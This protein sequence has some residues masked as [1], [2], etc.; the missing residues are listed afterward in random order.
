MAAT[1]HNE[2]PIPELSPEEHRLLDLTVKDLRAGRRV[3]VSA[4]QAR[5]MRAGEHDLD[6]IA[7]ADNAPARI[8]S[9][10]DGA[11]RPT[12]L[13]LSLVPD[14]G[15]LEHL[16]LAIALAVEHYEDES[17]LLTLGE[18]R[19]AKHLSRRDARCLAAVL[20]CEQHIFAAMP[21]GPFGRLDPRKCWRIDHAVRHFADVDSP[22]A[23]LSVLAS[24]P[25]AATDHGG[26]PTHPASPPPAWT[27]RAGQTFVD[28]LINAAATTLLALAVWGI[29]GPAT[30]QAP[31][32]PAQPSPPSAPHVQPAP[33]A[34]SR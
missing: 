13:G 9:V 30:A 28:G 8:G 10:V 19:S 23:Y 7:A 22:T 21:H 14:H 3:R 15:V 29:F 32:L 5:V 1:P 16:D 12:I 27:R 4:L 31:T 26:Q 20:D 2:P 34:T 25:P 18:L 11:F 24:H 17:P 6:I 33:S